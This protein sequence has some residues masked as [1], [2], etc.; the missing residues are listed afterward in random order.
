MQDWLVDWMWR[1][2]KSKNGAQSTEMMTF[3]GVAEVRSHFLFGGYDSEFHQGLLT[4]RLAYVRSVMQL[5]LYGGL[6]YFACF[7]CR[8]FGGGVLSPFHT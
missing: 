2:R 5:D 1:M 7:L 3:T 4:L 8:H 6:E